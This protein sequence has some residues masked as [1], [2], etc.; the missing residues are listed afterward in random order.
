MD[1]IL[2]D[3]LEH[4]NFKHSIEISKKHSKN[5]NLLIEFSIYY[6]MYFVDFRKNGK[7]RNHIFSCF[8]SNNFM[9]YTVDVSWISDR[10]LN[11]GFYSI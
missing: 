4:L 6:K 10:K 7:I 5:K 3:I 2:L 1:M 11:D 8:S 9:G